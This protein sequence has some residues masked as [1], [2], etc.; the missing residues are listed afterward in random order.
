M[1]VVILAGGLPSTIS[2]QNEPVPKPMV[3]IGERPLLWHIMKLYSSYGFHDFIV[4]GGY[5]IELIKEYFFNYYLYQSDITVDLEN[6]RIEIHKKKTES[7]KVNV[8][9][10]GQDTTTA[11]RILRVREA[12]REEDFILSYGDCISDIDVSKLVQTHN[13]NRAAV[14]M[15]VAR[16]TGRLASL[17]ID[18]EGR[19]NFP[20]RG[21][22]VSWSNA[23]NMVLRQQAF[24]YI[25]ENDRFEIETIE[26]MAA[27]G[28]VSTYEHSG[29]W[30]PVET[31]R[32]KEYLE[33][34]WNSRK[35]FLRQE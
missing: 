30:M 28:L 25:Y 9:Y 26:R 1:K 27:D 14:T 24:D 12:I 15:A 31:M 21:N 8:V 3:R 7:W 16:P 2:E 4:C 34:L 18:S 33:E 6:N 29:L 23:C 20:C 32:D 13:Q 10:T 35:Y 19:L 17:N 11:G 22:G 5:K